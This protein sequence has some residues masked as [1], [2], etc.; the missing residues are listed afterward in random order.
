[1]SKVPDGLSSVFERFFA[2]ERDSGLFSQEVCG[3][4]FWHYIRFYIYSVLVLP[5]FVPM[6]AA[7]PDMHAKVGAKPPG[8]LGKR[9]LSKCHR[10]WRMFRM[11]VIGNPSFALRRRDVLISLAPRTMSL[12]GGRRMRLAIDFFVER[13][14]SSW[15]VL[16]LPTAGSGYAVHDGSGRRFFWETVKRAICK[17]RASSGFK[18]QLPEISA[19]AKRLSEE[20]SE[21]LGIPVDEGVLRHRIESAVVLERAAVPLLRNWL[22]RL[23]VRCVVEVVHYCNANMALT[24]AAH[25]EGLPVV[26]LQHGTVY[27]AHVAYNLPVA[28][29]RC[30]P[31]YL[32]GWG[33][34]W[35]RQTRNFPAKRA[36][37]VGYPYLEHSLERFRCRTVRHGL[38]RVL[39]ISQGTAG[40][41][42]AEAAVQL[43]TMLPNDRF[44]I[45]FKLHPNETIRWRELYPCLLTS[46]VEVVENTARGVYECFAESDVTVG[47]CSTALIEGFMWGLKAFIIKNLAGSDTMAP[48]CD[49]TMAQYVDGVDELASALVATGESAGEMM[50]SGCA[51]AFFKTGS[52]AATSKIIDDFA[53]KRGEVL[54]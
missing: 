36:V 46:R 21:S 37:P 23:G 30:S 32:L 13:L 35:L 24:R 4:R 26:E 47:A 11:L 44:P 17:Y 27:P 19:V 28:D 25:E 52:A 22:R 2:F 29:S 10:V 14:K 45:V 20:M 12:D 6:D 50:A 8:G 38:V 42:L 48:F 1:M 9:V 41:Q 40:R 49:G 18:A 7:H 16:E 5:S 15:C 39:F 31:D 34:W 43:S 54:L 33:D 51:E 3:V 53:C